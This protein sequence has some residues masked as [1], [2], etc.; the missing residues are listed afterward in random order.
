[1]PVAMSPEEVDRLIEHC[2]T[3]R[4]REALQAC[5][6][7]GSQREAAEALG[8]HH[9]AVQGMV[10]RVKAHAA[11]KGGVQPTATPT[12]D[13]LPSKSGT[14]DE[15]KQAALKRF[16]R[17]LAYDTEK[18]FRKI[19][20]EDNLPIALGYIGDPHL[21]DDGCDWPSLTADTDTIVET[22]GF[23]ASNLGDTTNNWVG[24]LAR[25]YAH[26]ETTSAQ[27]WI[28]AEGWLKEIGPKLLMLVRGNHDAW[29]GESD[30]LPWI[31]SGHPATDVYEWNVRVALTFPECDPV[32]IWAAHNF[33]GHSQ[34]HTLHGMIKARLWHRDPAEIYACGHL[35]EWGFMSH[36]PTA[37]RVV[38]YLRARGYKF[39]DSYADELQ[40]PSQQFGRTIT[41][42]IDPVAPADR[43]VT[44]Y[45][46]VQEA[47]EYL[48]FKR[49]Q[50]K[51]V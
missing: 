22:P 25:L 46:S 4:Q 29:S 24:R 31:M 30:P 42:V 37:G 43:R 1:M 9:S 20:F 23:Y 48:T 34:Y 10:A 13:P 41:T 2:T 19:R 28:L 26:Q 40:F 39:C 17:R 12:F 45:S 32:R 5:K 15:L 7:H 27:A 16:E 21:D 49:Q 14:Y 18:R 3:D 35:H 6:I 36:E 38:H 44:V 8:I 47:A 50:R 11:S 33:K 51:Q